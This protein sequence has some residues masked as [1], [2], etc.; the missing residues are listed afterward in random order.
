M[1]D[2]DADA[3]T[4]SSNTRS[5]TL[6]SVP[7]SPGRSVLKRAN[8]VGAGFPHQTRHNALQ[9]QIANFQASLIRGAN[10]RGQCKKKP[11]KDV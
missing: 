5:Y 2:A 8:L 4:P 3:V 6:W 7:S 10:G 11:N 9:Y 1:T